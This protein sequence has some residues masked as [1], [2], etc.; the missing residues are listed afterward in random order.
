MIL[1][2]LVGGPAVVA[3]STYE[4]LIQKEASQSTSAFGQ[5]GLKEV[6]S[7]TNAI[8]GSLVKL[9]GVSAASETCEREKEGFNAWL[10]KKI[11]DYSLAA[12]NSIY[13]ISFR[14]AQIAYWVT[15]FTPFFLAAVV[16]GVMRRKIHL[17]CFRYTSPARYKLIWHSEIAIAASIFLAVP[18]AV[19][20]PSL[21]LPIALSIVALMTR[22]LIANIQPS[23]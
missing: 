14:I 20:W 23:V 1:L 7:V 16:D 9:T 3:P 11:C 17:H 6:G 12:A 13:L 22:M 15:Y 2:T 10:K 8:Y 21:F 4:G 18:L 19:G 5:M